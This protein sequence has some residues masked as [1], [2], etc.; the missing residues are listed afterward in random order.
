VFHRS[1]KDDEQVN[2]PTVLVTSAPERAVIA[3]ARALHIHGYRAVVV[4]SRAP[5]AGLWTRAAARC[6][7]LPDPLREPRKFTAQVAA[8]AVA[9]RVDVVLPGCDASLRAMSEHRHLLEGAVAHGRPSQ[10]AVWCSLDKLGLARA[11]KAA[12]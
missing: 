3:A 1:L 4:A 2:Q 8:V 9:H 12:A 5:A 6:Y 11:A 7:V 10:H